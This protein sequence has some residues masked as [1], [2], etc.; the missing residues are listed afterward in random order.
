MR[1]VRACRRRTSFSSGQTPPGL[2][3]P[4][5]RLIRLS[6]SYG[7]TR[8]R[9]EGMYLLYPITTVQPTVHSRAPPKRWNDEPRKGQPVSF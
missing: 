4:R 1:D 6:L 7:K 8:T 9:K 2:L 3:D 5:K